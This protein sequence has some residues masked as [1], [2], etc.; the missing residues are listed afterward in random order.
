MVLLSAWMQEWGEQ[1][2]HDVSLYKLRYRYR[3]RL[4]PHFQRGVSKQGI[5]NCG[6]KDRR[7]CGQNSTEF[8]NAVVREKRLRASTWLAG[9][10]GAWC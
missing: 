10:S 1:M 3:Q 5:V 2:I 6:S 7:C 4:F 9:W 8:L